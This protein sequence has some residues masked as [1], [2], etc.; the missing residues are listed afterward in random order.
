MP[1]DGAAVHPSP[2]TTKREHT[3][4][5]DSITSRYS[6]HTFVDDSKVLT[7][8]VALRH[9]LAIELLVLKGAFMTALFAFITAIVW[10]IYLCE[11]DC[12]FQ[13]RNNST[14]NATVLITKESKNDI[15]FLGFGTIALGAASHF[16][17]WGLTQLFVIGLR[18]R[19]PYSQL[20]F[21]PVYVL[22][23]LLLSYIFRTAVGVSGFSIALAAQ[24][25]SH[26]FA[27]LARTVYQREY[28]SVIKIFANVVVETLIIQCI[29]ATVCVYV[30]ATTNLASGLA[31]G[32]IVG[33][34]YPALELALK[35]LYRTQ[36]LA[37]P[38]TNPNDERLRRD[39]K[40]FTLV[41]RNLE[42][43]LGFPNFILLLMLPSNSIYVSALVSMCLLELV[44]NFV[45]NLR[46]TRAANIAMNKFQQRLKKNYSKKS[47]MQTIGAP[48]AISYVD[49][50]F[51]DS[52][53]ISSILKRSELSKIERKKKLFAVLRN[54]EEIGEKICSL[55]ALF[56][57]YFFIEAQLILRLDFMTLKNKLFR[58]ILLLVT[59]SAVDAVKIIIDNRFGIYGFKVK[60]EMT[61]FDAV[62]VATISVCAIGGFLV[63]YT[64]AVI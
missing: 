64:H 12:Y 40:A 37:P 29:F 51:G 59:E 23:F 55:T 15:A 60:N 33:F 42:I 56:A 22:S 43:V 36:V 3:F 5:D 11:T 19:E 50:G 58:G 54:N 24:V 63:A 7:V 45:S 13:E 44:G 10:N 49:D 46:F 38:S 25:C 21:G 39:Q 18:T 28:K 61:F 16:A 47:S 41:A 26:F 14:V 57:L 27:I 32:T 53:S 34:V 17:W 31:K 35:Y 52:E 8:G 4:K 48:G 20:L 62:N 6:F 2:V 30:W 9:S 1:R